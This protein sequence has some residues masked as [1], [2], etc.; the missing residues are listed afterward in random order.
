[1]HDTFVGD[2]MAGS[3]YTKT[4]KNYFNRLTREKN[5]S[6]RLIYVNT[7]QVVI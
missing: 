4:F 6:M 1:M 5:K 2:M 7:W 3:M